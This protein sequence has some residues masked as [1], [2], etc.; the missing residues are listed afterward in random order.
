[1]QHALKSLMAGLATSAAL[2]SCSP[3]H[4][5]STPEARAI[6][7]RTM[8]EAPDEYLD[9]GD[10]R[11]R[12]RVIGEGTPVLLLHGYT[13]R[14]EMWEAMAD[15]L[16]REYQ[17]IV[18][19][20][21]GFGLSTTFADPARYA[22][23]WIEDNV[24]LLDHLRIE[25]VH[26]VGYSLGGLIAAHLALDDPRRVRTVS[27]VAGA[28]YADSMHAVRELERFADD[29]DRTGDISTFF[30]YILPSWTP[31]AI[32]EI[33]P[34]IVAANDSVALGSTLRAIPAI[35]PDSARLSTA[36]VPALAIVGVKD[37][38]WPQ[39]V[40]IASKWPRTTLVELPEGDHADIFLRPE[41]IAE[42]RR[43]I[44][45]VGSGN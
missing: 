9:R 29:Y 3:L 1:M 5:D 17:V 36:K 42:V 32:A 8:A 11:I 45:E 31:S 16:A 24:A 19:D 27:F 22:P 18:P 44:A 35:V 7:A 33:L 13:D 21:R 28:T 20:L 43:F 2:V 41:V 38:L 39:A 40:F 12:Y 34:P 37:R 6:H 4:G 10:A 26:V 14:V 23:E 30:E 25:E 15:S